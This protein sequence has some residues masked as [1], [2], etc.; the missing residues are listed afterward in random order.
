MNITKKL[1]AIVCAI[2][3]VMSLSVTAF[4]KG[5]DI[6]TINSSCSTV[7]P[8]GEIT[9]SLE[10]KQ[11]FEC[12]MGGYI[13]F[14]YDEEKVSVKSIDPVYEADDVFDDGGE[15]GVGFNFPAGNYSVGLLGSITFSVKENISNGAEIVFTPSE[16]MDHDLEHVVNF[17]EFNEIK[18]IVNDASSGG[19]TPS[20]DPEPTT[21]YTVTM[22]E[23]TSN[24]VGETVTV[25]V[26]ISGDAYNA[27]DMSFTYNANVLELTMTDTNTEGYRVSGSD[28]TVR[29]QRYGAEVVAG[30]ALDLTFTAKAAGNADVV[31][32]SAKVD[33]AANSIEFNAPEAT[34]ADNTTVVTVTGYTVTLGD[35]FTKGD[36]EA[37]LVVEAGDDFT[38]KPVDPNYDYTVTV[39]VNG[40]EVPA[41]KVIANS[42]GSFTI[43]N[44]NGNVKVSATKTPKTFAVTLGDDMT[45]AQAGNAVYKTDYVFTLAKAANSAYDVKVTIGGTDYTGFNAVDNGDGTVTYTIPGADIT[46]PV[47]V[48]SNKVTTI[49]HTVTFAGSGAGDKTSGAAEVENGQ[50]Y[51]FTVDKKDNYTYTVTAKMG[52]N[53]ADVTEENGTYKIANVTGDLVITINKEAEY[54]VAVSAYVEMNDK[55]MFLITVTGTPDSGKVFAYDGNAMYKTA[56]YGENVYSYLV[57]VDKSAAAPTAE[58]AKA[59]ITQITAEAVVLEQTYDVN[60]S[61]KVDIN[62]AQLVYDMYNGAYSDFTAV[63]VEKFLRADVNFDKTINVQDASAIV[64]EIQ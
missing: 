37:D 11:A 57:I 30:K 7:M 34:I 36:G 62:D 28:G 20:T 14:F 54:E 1:L 60:A 13:A 52:E 50:D 33:K 8:G 47:A 38:F 42:D 56:A 59:M 41:D 32:T 49:K 63:T 5:E 45:A 46:G 25:P 21:G 12:N 27:Y 9:L 61:N 44:V 15:Y 4:A 2:A 58:T 10:A 55:T 48:N 18:I 29:V 43:K 31:C 35:D 23:D 6:V 40:E 26:S 64:N 24:V 22:G 51:T 19:N 53:D 16:S 39:T 3:I 17:N